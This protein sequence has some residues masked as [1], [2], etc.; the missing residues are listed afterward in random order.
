MIAPAISVHP[1][2]E[3]LDRSPLGVLVHDSR[4]RIVHAN[5]SF[6]HLVDHS[7]TD[8]L[9]MTADQLVAPVDRPNREQLVRRL[10]SG[11]LDD[12]TVDRRLI[13]RQGRILFVRVFNSAIWVGDDR[14]IMVCITDVRDWQQRVDQLGYAAAHDELTGLLNRSGLADEVG[15]LPVTGRSG[16]LAVLDLNGLK[17]VNDVYG[18]AAG[19]QL[20]RA[21]AELLTA[22]A[23]PGWLIGRLGGDEFVVVDADSDGDLDGEPELGRV[24]QAALTTTVTVAPGASILMS[25]SVGEVP[26]T[27]RDDFDEALRDADREMYRHKRSG[28]CAIAGDA[29]QAGPPANHLGQGHRVGSRSAEPPRYFRPGVQFMPQLYL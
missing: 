8:L 19:D 24:I 18:H 5:A 4:D 11:E 26:F 13:D 15:Q 25:A 9:S 1:W 2:L 17:S 23:G 28:R 6:A 21:T 10:R 7:L 14:L 20:L 29:G 27:S 22:A 12:A 16:R 3:L